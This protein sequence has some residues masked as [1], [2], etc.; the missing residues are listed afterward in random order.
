MKRSLLLALLVGAA[1]VG[2]S[3]LV[4]VRKPPVLPEVLPTLPA[5]GTWDELSDMPWQ[6]A[7]TGWLA[8]ANDGQPTKSI[9]L[10]GSQISI[11]GEHYSQG[12][13]TYPPSEITYQLDG[14]YT[15]FAA[16]VGIDD[17]SEQGTARFL[18]FL[19]DIL[20]YDSGVMT[21]GEPA[22]KV[23]VDIT[24]GRQLRLLVN[25]R[26]GD[27]SVTYTNWADAQLFRPLFSPDRRKAG[28]AISKRQAL[29]RIRKVEQENQ[30]KEVRERAKAGIASLQSFEKTTGV[31]GPSGI[32]TGL[33][34]SRSLLVLMNERIGITLGFGGQEHGFITVTDLTRDELVFYDTS[35]SLTVPG[36]GNIN[37]HEHTEPEV[38]DAFRFTAFHDSVLGD[39]ERLEARMKTK[40]GGLIITAIISLFRDSTYF[41]YQLSL[42]GESIEISPIFNFFGL[43]YNNL[44]LGEGA[45]YITDYSRLIRTKIKDD[46]LQ[47]QESVG[48]GKPVFIWNNRNSKGLILAT[49]DETRSLTRF[50]VQLDKGRAVARF[51]FSDGKAIDPSSSSSAI[52]SPRL[53]VELTSAPSVS[54]AFANFR[55]VTSALHPQA[56]LP[57]W[58]KYQWLSWYV[59]YM[60][61]NETVIKHQIDYIADNLADLGPWHIIIDA[62]WYIAE[63]RDGADW[64]NVDRN[65]FPSGLRS[66]VD[67]AHSKG[68]KVVLYFSA[69]Y[70]DSREREGD[71]LGLRNFIEKHRDWLIALGEDE[72]RQS[73]V[74]DFSNSGLLDYMKTVMQDFFLNYGVDGIKVDGLGNAEGALLDPHRLDRFGLVESATSQ[75]MDI[76]RFVYENASTS[77]D[78]VYIESGWLSPI[79]ANPY[80][81]TFRYGDESN[82]FSNHYPTPG[83]VEHIRY[84]VIQKMLL[85]QRP[86][87]GAV[88][89]DPNSSEINRWWIQAGLA[90][91]T[92]VVL[93]FNLQEMSEETL[94]E[95]RAMLNHYNAFEGETYIPDALDPRTF[96]TQVEGTT[97][98]G[99]L[100]PE[101][102]NVRVSVDLSKYGLTPRETYLAYDVSTGAGSKVRGTM[103]VEMPGES[104]RLFLLRQA[105]GILWTNSSFDEQESDEGM[106]IS[107]SGP[108]SIDGFIRVYTPR[109]KAVYLDG[110][111]LIR[112]RSSTLAIGTFNYRNQSGLLTIAY[113]HDQEHEIY[114][115]Y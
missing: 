91:G 71:W 53:Y 32:V 57:S 18:V 63:G 14:E 70:L 50:V 83:L 39:G 38:P 13:G 110:Q 90:L 27:S 26:A 100:N 66:L 112:T 65:K 94:S 79:F 77:N 113:D 64:R 88:F 6:S 1:I 114:I 47:R 55:S 97:Y 45:E 82:E 106:R 15:V 42:E 56:P 67:Y 73:Y 12:I 86:N 72:S 40:A 81:H 28:A 98:L 34:R 93:S 107:V 5:I 85:A 44:V 61:M 108:S 75:T 52:F 36:K 68:I 8:V 4:L 84:A 51:A 54:D 2:L 17:G 76:Y 99:V 111:P 19:D 115:E 74:Y 102:G 105:P 31:A 78:Q 43:R 7:S 20:T 24:G 58:V 37:L 29:N 10:K 80:A 46:S 35:S 22:K 109:L 87:M 96:A 30:M 33:D 92:Q 104:F 89:D 16:Q 49:M 62:G 9:N 41:T 60:D 48:Q 95:Y 23:E 103:G 11:A 59:Y 3:A 21:T 101:P 25:K 69:P